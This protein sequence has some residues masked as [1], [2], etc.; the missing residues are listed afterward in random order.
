MSE[1]YKSQLFEIKSHIADVQSINPDFYEYGYKTFE[2]SN[3]LYLQY[4]RANYEDKAKILK[5]VASNYTLDD[6]NLYA[7]YRKLFDII[8]E[9]MSCPDGYPGRTRTSNE[10]IKI[11]SVA[12]TL[13]GNFVIFLLD[14]DFDVNSVER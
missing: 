2:L 3:K 1:E 12:I 6:V 14:T 9:G 8:A 7:A 11:S 4:V 5:Y 10:R 13:P